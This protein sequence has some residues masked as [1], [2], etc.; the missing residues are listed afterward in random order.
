[1][2]ICQ[3]DKTTFGHGHGGYDKAGMGLLSQIKEK[4]GIKKGGQVVVLSDVHRC[5][6]LPTYLHIAI[7]LKMH[8]SDQNQSC[9]GCMK[10]STLHVASQKYAA[11][12]AIGPMLKGSRK[13]VQYAKKID[14]STAKYSV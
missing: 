7:F 3:E 13:L 5:C 10:Q 12:V 6:P 11:L 2:D 9:L 8:Y 14:F 4:S 1:L